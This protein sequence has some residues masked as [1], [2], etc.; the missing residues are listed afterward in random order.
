MRILSLVV[1]CLMLMTSNLNSQSNDDIYVLKL[2]MNQKGIHDTLKFQLLVS[3][4]Q[5]ALVYRISYWD[6][7]VTIT[8]KYL[9]E[10][11]KPMEIIAT[12]NVQL[13][14]LS[15][16]AWL[17]SNEGNDDKALKYYFLAVENRRIAS[18]KINE[19]RI[20]DKIAAIHFEAKD[21][22]SAVK[23][24]EQSLEL[25]REFGSQNE[26]AYA[27]IQL[28]NV[29][30]RVL[31][32]YEIGLKHYAEAFDIFKELDDKRGLADVL[33]N[34]G[35]ILEFQGKLEEALGYYLRSLA[36][37][38]QVDE[39]Y[40]LGVSLNDI[41]SVEMK[42]GKFSDAKGHLEES[43]KLAYELGDPREIAF[44]AE[45]LY[46][47]AKEE[48]EGFKALEY[49]QVFIQNRDSINSEK[50]R[51]SIAKFNLDKQKSIDKAVYE[52]NLEIVK[53]R[54][55]KQQMIS[56]F[57]FGG[58]FLIGLFL[59]FVTNR[60]KVTRK[61]R[62][63]I[64]SQKEVV[65]SSL[66]KVEIQKQEIEEVHKEI[67]DSIDYAERIQFSFLATKELL[68][69]NLGEH[70]VFFRP[71]DVVSGDFYWADELSN[72]DFAVVNADSTGHG[73]PGAIMSILNI[74]SI[75]RAVEN[76]ALTPASIFNEA[77][78]RI[79][80]RLKKDGSEH[81]GKDGMDASIVCFNANK[82][83]MTYTAAQNP[84]WVIRA[85]EVI[86]IKAEKMPVG[87]HDNDHIPFKGG[88]FDLQKGDQVYTL[89][90][91][92]QDQFGGPKGKKFMIKK[93]REYVL[94]ISH[95]SMEEQYQKLDEVFSNWKGDV[96]Q[97]D[98]VCVIGVKV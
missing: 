27:I 66:Y 23:Y 92:F 42:L 53:E 19:A 7:L 29:Y 96:E 12:S 87:K 78:Q 80:D 59:L 36:Y 65:E 71:K 93:M 97:V 50:S 56:Y 84:I 4:G 2:Q 39:K 22:E 11:H 26:I 17:A 61:Q 16:M 57:A 5:K 33:N 18:D 1:F 3:I 74:S 70:F 94:S 37:V 98:D 91:G 49:Y 68:D 75:E 72:G 32:V 31:P 44:T 30:K 15:N 8:Q 48:N 14:S 13:R 95:L 69:N 90:D 6:S 82:T 67:T 64:D 34:I 24:L 81:G 51:E 10:N 43:L 73:V 58:L 28:G 88:E 79:I 35:T 60:L 46:K 83:K 55:H 85:G 9:S 63:L 41:G 40:L 86:Q 77:R 54:E 20:L 76:K 25:Y 52:K 38:K 21:G 47:I 89:T 45:N 62:D